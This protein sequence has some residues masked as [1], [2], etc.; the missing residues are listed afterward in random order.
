MKAKKPINVEVGRRV[1]MAREAAGL[2][3]E[4]FSEMIGLG[5]KHVTAIECGAAG[6]SLST[7][8]K[9]STLLSIPADYL[10]FDPSDTAP[11]DER[12]ATLEMLTTRL[13]RLPDREF[14]VAT[15]ILDKTLEAFTCGKLQ[16]DV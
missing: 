5:V 7:L 11:S 13:S 2:T 12:T 6:V 15:E 10:L 16:E 3:Q 4:N 1:K 9:M 14:R 8:V